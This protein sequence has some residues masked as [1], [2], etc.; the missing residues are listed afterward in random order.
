MNYEFYWII[1]ICILSSF[2]P[3]LMH[4]YPKCYLH[5]HFIY[6]QVGPS[7]SRFYHSP[8]ETLHATVGPRTLLP[9]SYRV[10]PR[11][12]TPAA[13]LPSL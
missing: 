1:G 6:A 8:S 4:C 5:D 13:A 10:F 3:T 9:P 7:A 2:T 11:F 12:L